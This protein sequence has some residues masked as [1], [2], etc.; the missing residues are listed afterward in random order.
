[1]PAQPLVVGADDQA[2]SSWAATAAEIERLNR[3]D[4]LLGLEKALAWQDHERSVGCPMGLAC[5]IRVH[6]SALRFLGRYDEAIERFEDAAA[7]F[8]ALGLPAEAAL[9]QIGHVAAL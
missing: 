9:G 7:R 5:A 4:P 2:R 6:A 8:Y 3:S 1:M